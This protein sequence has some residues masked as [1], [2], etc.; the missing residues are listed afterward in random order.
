MEVP[1]AAIRHLPWRD[2][3]LSPGT[4]RGPCSHTPSD[5]RTCDQFW[6]A[7]CPELRGAPGAEGCLTWSSGVG[8]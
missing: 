1:S 6:A 5:L 4:G 2:T 3:A 8:P 7:Q